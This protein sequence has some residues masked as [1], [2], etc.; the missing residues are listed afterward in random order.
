MT[1]EQTLSIIK[2]DAVEG[3]H[4]GAILAR[5]EKAGLKVV[6]A[7]MMH[8]STE[9]AEGFY[10]VHKHRPF[11][12]E[13]VSF[14]ITGPVLISVLEGD[15][16]IAKNRTLMGATDPKKAEKGTIR[17]DFADSIEKNAVHGSDSHDN[18]K[19]EIAFFFKKSEIFPR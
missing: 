11:F 18:A 3:N 1:R 16:A 8:L 13:L 4:I 9:Q 7:K 14:M 15:H 5:F 2:P 19:T 6:A 12:Q 17:A 10:A